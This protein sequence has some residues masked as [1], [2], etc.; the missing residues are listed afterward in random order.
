VVELS[1]SGI[2]GQA[3]GWAQHLLDVDIEDTVAP[4]VLQVA[5][6]PASGGSVEV[7]VDQLTVD[8]SEELAPAPANVL[9]RM[10]WSYG[11]HF[12][13]VTEGTASWSQAQDEGESWGGHPVEEDVTGH[14]FRSTSRLSTLCCIRDED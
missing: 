8:F 12:Y 4:T 2:G 11:G 13:L 5:P 1:G 9:E 6:L 3:G 10:A 7:V 14:R